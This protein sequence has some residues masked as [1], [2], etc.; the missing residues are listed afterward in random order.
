MKS[1]TTTNDQSSS[2]NYPFTLNQYRE[3]IKTRSRKEIAEIYG[4]T[5]RQVARY[6]QKL[7]RAEKIKESKK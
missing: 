3:M 2:V 1:L 5:L 6:T 4:I 7:R